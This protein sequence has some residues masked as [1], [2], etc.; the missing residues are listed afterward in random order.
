MAGIKL[1]CD[2]RPRHNFES[3][4]EIVGDAYES[5]TSF[6]DF[7]SFFM[8]K[9]VN[10]SWG[11]DVLFSRFSECE[12]VFTQEFSFL[13]SHFEAYSRNIRVALSMDLGK[14]V[15]ENEYETVPF[16]YH[17]DCGSK[18]RLKAEFQGRTFL[19]RG[20]CLGCQKEHE[21]DFG[22]KEEPKISEISSRI[23][24]R[25][26]SMPLVFFE[27]LGVCCYVGGVGGKRYLAQ[28][29]YVAHSMGMTFPLIAIWRPR[30]IYSGMGQLEAL[31]AFERISGTFDLSHYSL[32]RTR[33]LEKVA[34][35]Q[36]EIDK[37]EMEKRVSERT[38][39]EEGIKTLEEL[40]RL[41][42][43][44]NALR[45]SENFSSLIRNLKLLENV[46]SVLNMYPSVID[47]ALN[48][49]LPETSKQWMD[50]LEEKGDF[51]SEVSLVTFLDEI[52]LRLRKS[53]QN[54]IIGG[55]N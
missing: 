13:I 22:A 36:K 12:Q 18:A 11:Y 37:L 48:I 15:F 51:S 23:S 29:E 26:V 21:I 30:D 38:K 43:R 2:D 33:M 34:S 28:A 55:V 25:S 9:I 19:G 4:W 39:S 54:S 24:A 3:F 20:K 50:F 5:A 45:R 49:G 16:W 35:V 31:I 7:N 14:G 27:G 8:S 46:V 17:C 40:K 47:Y 10:K 52:A 53:G 41:S 32:V 1:D 44:Q 42:A 6:S